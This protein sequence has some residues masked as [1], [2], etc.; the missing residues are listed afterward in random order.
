[1]QLTGTPRLIVSVI[2]ASSSSIVVGSLIAANTPAALTVTEKV[3]M[4]IGG[5]GLGLAA[6]AIAAKYTLEHIDETLETIEMLKTALNKAK[7][8]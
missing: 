3:T 2:V 8:N 5:Y 4:K 6:G 7:T 1:M